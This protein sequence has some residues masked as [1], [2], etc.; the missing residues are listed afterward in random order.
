MQILLH[1]YFKRAFT[2]FLKP[3]FTDM[4]KATKD[5]VKNT[6]AKINFKFSSTA[7]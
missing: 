2:V 7:L 1:N 4:N 5:S 3:A 6:H